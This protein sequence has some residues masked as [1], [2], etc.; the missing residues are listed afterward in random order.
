LLAELGAGEEAQRLSELMESLESGRRMDA[1]EELGRMADA[2]EALQDNLEA[3]LERFRRAA[4]EESFLGAEED[5]RTLAEEQEELARILAGENGRDD[6]GEPGAT[7]PGTREHD[8]GSPDAESPE[9]QAG[10]TDPVASQESLLAGVDPVRERLQD[11][12]RR[13]GREGEEAAS[14]AAGEAGRQLEQAKEAMERAAEAARSGDSDGAAGEAGEAGE[15]AQRALDELEEARRD[16]MEAF[17]EALRATLRQGAEEALALARRQDDLRA[18]MERAGRVERGELRSDEAALVQ[19]VRNL[20]NRLEA[21]N[22]Q[23]PEVGRELA[24]ALGDALAAGE[25][26]VDQLGRSG[27]WGGGRFDEAAA[28]TAEALNRAAVLALSG[29]EQVGQGGEGSAMEQL[30]EELEALAEAQEAANQQAQA[31][32]GEGSEEGQGASTMEEAASAQ[33]DVADA[34]RN[35]AS[36]EAGEWSPGDLD[37]MAQEAEALAEALESGTL[38]RELIRRQE[39]LLERFL[40]AGRMLERD[41]PTEE[42]EGTPAG[43]VERPL[44]PSLDPDLLRDGRLAPPSPEELRHLTPAERRLVLEYFE[45]LNRSTSPGDGNGGQP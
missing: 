3:V 20:A 2:R 44:I 30:M 12:E 15:M 5:L 32:S 37:E 13:L 10:A 33:R 39:E 16:W 43:V 34:A 14:Q 25:R 11:L 17:E 24:R 35:L 21:V 23:L 41:G 29:M 9:E 1:A 7:E 38:D 36:G 27:L 22:R 40:D 18:R 42:R 26:T 28:R 19:G 6:A 45:A 8:A 31:S 4:L